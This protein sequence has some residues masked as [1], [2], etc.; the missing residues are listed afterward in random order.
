VVVPVTGKIYRRECAR[1]DSG[2]PEWERVA[3]INDWVRNVYLYD[4]KMP[5][6]VNHQPKYDD[7]VLTKKELRCI[8]SQLGSGLTSVNPKEIASF[9]N[10]AGSLLHKRTKS[11]MH[12]PKACRGAQTK[13]GFLAFPYHY[14]KQSRYGEGIVLTG[15]HNCFPRF[16]KL[17]YISGA[18][19]ELAGFRSDKDKLKYVFFIE[20]HRNLVLSG[21][22]YL[23]ETDENYF[24]ER[25]A[26]VLH[27]PVYEPVEITIA[28]QRA[29]SKAAS[30]TR[31]TS[32]EL[33]LA[34]Y[35]GEYLA[36]IKAGQDVTKV[37]NYLL[38]KVFKDG[39]P[40]LQRPL[41]IDM[42]RIDKNNYPLHEIDE[43]I[44]VLGKVTN[45]LMT[46]DIKSKLA[47]E[48]KAGKLLYSLYV[49]GANHKPG[50]DA[51]YEQD[52]SN[53]PHR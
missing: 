46:G 1:S 11:K 19:L 45:A 28:D 33:R 44:A 41:I 47:K 52:R 25:I 23:S 51:V 21:K 2:C 7:Y 22:T 16:A 20:G 6:C 50:V 53:I 36:R 31:Y 14:L 48:R 35:L 17:F 40:H 3:V 24:F 15:Y 18:E 4:T 30:E 9:L 5:K 34:V 13:G 26:D 27:I 38:R 37:R 32:D 10:R 29:I 12:N 39:Y 8:E 42:M 49:I 43:K